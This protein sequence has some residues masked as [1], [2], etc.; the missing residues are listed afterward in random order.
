MKISE[1]EVRKHPVVIVE[2]YRIG[3]SFGF[4]EIAW[5]SRE[6]K[7]H[8]YARL[9]ERQIPAHIPGGAAA[10]I[11]RNQGYM[12]QVSSEDPNGIKVLFR[13]RDF[14]EAI[15]WAKR[16]FNIHLETAP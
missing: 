12:H 16:Q 1:S 6:E 15:N 2:S 14:Q 4:I 13:S 3:M 5:H 9:R 10:V 11:R 8:L 7:F